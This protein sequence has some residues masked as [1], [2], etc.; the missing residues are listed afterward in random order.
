[1]PITN[2][3]I[4]GSGSTGY[5]AAIYARRAQLKPIVVE[6]FKAGGVPG[7]QLM[8]T[9]D[10]LDLDSVSFGDREQYKRLGLLWSKTQSLKHD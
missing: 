1:M 8:T 3:V 4:I 6:G 7:R 10:V 5:M 2:L 9:T